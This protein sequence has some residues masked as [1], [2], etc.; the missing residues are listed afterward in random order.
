L[1]AKNRAVGVHNLDAPIARIDA[2]TAVRPVT[3]TTGL[4]SEADI[5]P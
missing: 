1:L 5:V 3:G 2:A 4:D